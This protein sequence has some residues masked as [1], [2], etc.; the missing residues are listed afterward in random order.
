MEIVIYT[1]VEIAGTMKPRAG[2]NEDRPIKPFWAV[3]ARG[4]TA[5]RG[6]VIIAVGTFR[7]DTNGDAD[8]SICF[9]DAC[10]EAAH[11]DRA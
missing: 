1:A 5:I 3:V 9:R 7:S 10:G 4:S 6:R 11:S 8:L 2:A